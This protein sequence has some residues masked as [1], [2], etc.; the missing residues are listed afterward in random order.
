[1]KE[2]LLKQKDMDTSRT[3]AEDSCNIGVL[4]S[5]QH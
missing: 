2:G 1:M 3:G 5:R 4:Y